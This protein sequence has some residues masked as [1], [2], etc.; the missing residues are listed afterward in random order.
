MR[1]RRINGDD[2]V[3]LFKHRRS[4][5]EVTKPGPQIHHQ[6]LAA[7][8][9]DIGFSRSFLQAEDRDTRHT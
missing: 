5:G 6:S 7:V 3:Q 2:Q 9:H 4:I 8:F 1:H